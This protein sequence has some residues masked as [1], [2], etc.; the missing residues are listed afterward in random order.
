MYIDHMKHYNQPQ[1]ERGEL[2]VSWQMSL[3]LVCQAPKA[4]PPEKVL[5][6]AH[7]SKQHANQGSYSQ[8][9]S[10]ACK[11]VSLVLQLRPHAIWRS[12]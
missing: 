11:Y 8:N 3:M 5:P 4:T 7:A 1:N 12:G 2:A 6:H 10:S 9:M